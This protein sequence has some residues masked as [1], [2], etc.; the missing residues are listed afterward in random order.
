MTSAA[1][2]VSV[3]VPA[4]NAQET[5]VECVRS[6]LAQTYPRDRYE[7][8]VV[9]NG[10][11]DRTRAL[12]AEFEP[13]IAVLAQATRGAG[14]ARNAGVRE[15]AGEIVAFTD[16]DCTADAEW[17]SELVWP[18]ADPAIGICGGQILA[19]RPATAAEL[20]GEVVHDHAAAM[21]VFSPP[22]AV[23]MNWA[24]P[25]SLLAELG[26]FDERLLRSQDAELA[27]RAARAG[28]RLAY[29]PAAIVY[30]RNEQT[31][32]GLFREGLQHGF[33]GRRVVRLHREFVAAQRRESPR[34]PRSAPPGQT[35]RYRIAFRAGRRIGRVAGAVWWTIRS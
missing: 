32:R 1:P 16:A 12:L 25:A 20:F 17:L 8:L 2:L 13:A 33:H 6:L 24:S 18:L 11:T 26:G 19:R 4:R 14:A 30:H 28:Y 3:V 7:I 34:Q 29:C 10:S 23:T 5:I 35:A 9:D 21:L 27:Y 15:A 31:G 22:Y